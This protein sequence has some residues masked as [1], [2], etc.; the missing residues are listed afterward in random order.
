M[1][2][3]AKDARQALDVAEVIPNG[4]PPQPDEAV[5]WRFQSVGF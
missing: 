4:A 5:W 3:G 2:E 1:A